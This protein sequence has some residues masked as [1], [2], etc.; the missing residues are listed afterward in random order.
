MQMQVVDRLTAIFA[1][2]DHHAIALC[3]AKVA[4]DLRCCGEQVAE[5][6]GIAP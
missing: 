2:I 6:F 3:K 5:E 4:S 1:S